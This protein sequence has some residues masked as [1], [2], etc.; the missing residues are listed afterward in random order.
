MEK[1][2]VIVAGTSCFVEEL[3]VGVHNLSDRRERKDKAGNSCKSK[4]FFG[5]IDVF[6]RN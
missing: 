2:P 3:T 1:R 4:P 5:R 6:W